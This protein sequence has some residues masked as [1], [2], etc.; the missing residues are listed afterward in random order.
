MESHKRLDNISLIVTCKD[1]VVANEIII[2]N[3][4]YRILDDKTAWVIG[5]IG[6]PQ[7]LII[8][9]KIKYD[10][11]SFKVDTI[12]KNAFKDCTS[13]KSVEIADSVTSIGFS[14]FYNCY[15]LNNVKLSKNIERIGSCVFQDCY[16][17]DS[18]TIPDGVCRIESSTFDGSGLFSIVIPTSMTYINARAFRNCMS[19]SAVFIMDLRKIII[20]NRLR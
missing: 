15:R 3:I 5:Y 17:L 19:F 18:I 9:S 7:N 12:V 14:A 2:E 20:D 6:E 1:T 8:P 13:L 16:A 4:K 11:F 10:G